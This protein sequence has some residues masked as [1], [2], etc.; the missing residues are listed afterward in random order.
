[1]KLSTLCAFVPKYGAAKCRH[2]GSTDV[3]LSKTLAH[4]KLFCV[5][6]CRAC[7]RHFRDGINLR[8]FMPHL[9]TLVAL[10]GMLLML[11]GIFYFSF[12]NETSVDTLLL[13]DRSSQNR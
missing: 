3:R 9:I 4:K 5:Y 1:M 12:S 8:M 7:G 2:C 10:I 11:I 6:R 13:Q